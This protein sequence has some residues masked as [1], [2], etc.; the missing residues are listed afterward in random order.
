MASALFFGPAM[1]APQQ[2]LDLWKEQIAGCV[3]MT[4]SMAVR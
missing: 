4:A 3:V 2:L 1:T